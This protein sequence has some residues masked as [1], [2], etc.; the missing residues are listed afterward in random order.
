MVV[1]NVVDLGVLLGQ[2]SAEHDLQRK[3]AHD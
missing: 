3:L 2:Q 1:L